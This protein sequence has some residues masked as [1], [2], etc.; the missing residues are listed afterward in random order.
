MNDTPNT[1]PS[2]E[3]RAASKR[4][5]FHALAAVGLLVVGT[6]AVRGLEVGMNATFSKPPAP[7]SKPLNELTRRIGSHYISERPDEVLDHE[8][9]ETLGTHDYLVREY[10]DN[11]V[12]PGE[13]GELINLNVNYYATGSSSP[14]VPEVCWVGSGRHEAPGSGEVF[15]IADVPRKY[16]PPVTLKVKLISFLP[17]R[18][19]TSQVEELPPA[20][21]GEPLYTNVA[22]IFHVNGEYVSNVREVT[23]HFWKA[24]NLYA[25]HSKIEITPMMRAGTPDGPRVVPALSTRRQAKEIVSRFFREGLAEIEECLPDPAIL[26]TPPKAAADG[27]PGVNTR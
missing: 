26:T 25:Y 18:G 6:A 5:L 10:R 15:E 2:P 3:V 24:S 1:S 8:V 22:Y 23:T 13:L 11:R 4:T 16:G 27:A 12:K 7:L 21:D 9:M 17:T 20:A 19:G 14:H